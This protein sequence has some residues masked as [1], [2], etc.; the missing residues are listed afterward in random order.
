MTTTLWIGAP[1]MGTWILR[2]IAWR[3]RPGSSHWHCGGDLVQQI[4]K[5]PVARDVVSRQPCT[6]LILRRAHDC[7]LRCDFNDL[8][9]VNLICTYNLHK[10]FVTHV[11]VSGRKRMQ[12]QGRGRLRR[13]A[14]CRA[15]PPTLW[16]AS[17]GHRHSTK[18]E[19]ITNESK[20][21]R[22][23]HASRVFRSENKRSYAL[24]RDEGHDRT[25][26]TQ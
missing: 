2:A 6:T 15:T 23:H 17:S 16:G 1:Q 9:I 14:S 3:L 20:A 10:T 7:S 18:L 11:L 24:R 21:A 19:L 5:S 4:A 8:C 22:A 25:R 13:P 26:V 12:P